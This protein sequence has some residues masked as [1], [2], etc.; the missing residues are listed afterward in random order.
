M[1]YESFKRARL[2]VLG[3][4]IST[5]GVGG[6]SE[7]SLHKILKLTLEPDT[8][9][10]EVKFLGSIADIKNDS[11]VF[12]VQTKAPYLLERKLE[13]FLP[14]TK[15]T[16]VMPLICE[17]RIRWIDT[18]TGE[19][20]EPKKSPKKEDVYT[21]LNALC[22]ISKFIGNHNF[23]VKLMLLSVDE[24]RRLDGYDKTKK[25]GASKA[26]KIPSELLDV[27][28]LKSPE[29][30]EKY[31]PEGISGEFF[32]KDFA[33]AIKRPSR[34]T[35]FVIKLFC[36]LGF[37]SKVGNVG[38]AIVYKRKDKWLNVKSTCL[39]YAFIVIFSLVFGCVNERPVH[40]KK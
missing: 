36:E 20:G 32:A 33:A 15:V 12:E 18:E 4:D 30:Y 29:D 19:I 26:D 3:N 40:L 39:F 7:K 23:S 10:H 34:F 13:K 37:V 8:E 21:A 16:L 27:I 6:L 11:G 38:R 2:L 31:V 9:K 17:K 14:H 1:I 5:A 35:Y 22:P 25:R 24:Y 28:D